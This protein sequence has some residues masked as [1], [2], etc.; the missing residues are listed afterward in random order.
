MGFFDSDLSYPTVRTERMKHK[1]RRLVQGPNSYFMDVK[2]PG[3]KN[4]TVVYSHATSEV[5]CNGCATLLC[6][7]TGGKAMLV[8]GCGF[9]KKPDH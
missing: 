9:R 2:C 8:T 6:R 1:R 5:K 4:I 3:C 7:P